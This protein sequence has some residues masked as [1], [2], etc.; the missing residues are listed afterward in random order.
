MVNDACLVDGPAV[1]VGTNLG[2]V[3]VVVGWG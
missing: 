3:V 1:D 2:T